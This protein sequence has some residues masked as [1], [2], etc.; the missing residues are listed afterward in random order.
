MQLPRVGPWPR[1]FRLVRPHRLFRLAMIRAEGDLVGRR[2][3]HLEVEEL[4][5]VLESMVG[6][7]GETAE[8]DIDNGG[9]V[10]AVKSTADT[11]N[12][13]FA[14]AHAASRWQRQ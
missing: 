3:D 12:R 9:C 6:I 10:L 11:H 14:R 5:V 7:D 13:R 8:R 1:L 2:V 4:D